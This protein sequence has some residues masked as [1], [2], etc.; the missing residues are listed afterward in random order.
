MKIISA[1]LVALLLISSASAFRIMHN[2][3]QNKYA[4]TGV[5]CSKS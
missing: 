2:R 3:I 5:P 4:D 1:I